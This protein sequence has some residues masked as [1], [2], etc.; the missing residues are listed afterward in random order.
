MRISIKYAVAASIFASMAV[1]GCAKKADKISATYV[2]PLQYS[3]YDC[4]QIRQELVRVS[5]MVREVSGAQDKEAEGDAI[6]TGVGLVLFWPALFFLM[7]DDQAQELGLLKGEYDSLQSAATEKKCEI[8]AE[9]QEAQRLDD[10][11]RS[12]MKEK[13]GDWGKNY[14]TGT[15]PHNLSTL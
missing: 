10:E 3:R 11:R 13:T 5:S 6:A 7:G 1:S 12:A 4:A 2:S 14:G 8:A 9:I 15:N